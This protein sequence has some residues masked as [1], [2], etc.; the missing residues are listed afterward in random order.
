[1][2][3]S[4]RILNLILG[5]L[6]IIT[7]LA[8]GCTGSTT[9]AT[10]S[11][12]SNDKF[13]LWSDGTK[14]RG[15]NI[16]QRIIYP[17][18]YDDPEIWGNGP[19]GPVYTQADFNALESAGANFV[20]LSHPG[21]YDDQPPYALNTDIQNN[22]D[23]YIDMAEKA[24]LFV[25]ISFRTGPGRSEFSF[26]GVAEDDAFGQAHL[27]DDVWENTAAQDKWVEMWRYTA[28]R[29][30]HQPNVVGYELMV[31][32]NANGIWLDLW[33]PEDFY[34][35]YQ[36][37]TYDWNQLY[38]RIITA[39]REFDN[40][41]PIIVGA[42]GWSAVK[43]LPSLK[44]V[45]DN[46]IVYAIH[47]YEPQDQYV[48]QG[49][50]G[51]GPFPNTYPGVFDANYDG[52]NEDFNKAWINDL[53]ATVN[54]FKTQHSVPVIATEYGVVRWE[55]GAAQFLNDEMA[56]FEASGINYA[57]WLWNPSSPGYNGAH[58]EMN[59]RFGADPADLTEGHSD[60]LN[61]LKQY[62]AKNSVR[63]SSFK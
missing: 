29:Y 54:Q 60:L 26:F 55:P 3:K 43:W 24:D 40:D 4:G 46:R 28:T 20:V 34:P 51:T 31:E 61:V 44:T 50:D 32:P 9:T 62:W 53:L 17:N 27:N 56:S 38:P 41:T 37:S 23:R 63:L 35:T 25:V 59:Y 6:V 58:N 22:L 11:T 1:M 14:L 57:I 8:A 15:A 12:T 2:K 7:L 21:L 13:S 47:Q 39:I 36:N 42:M 48:L 10:T 52:R 5:L 16:Y 49:A 18:I 30:C 19:L 45:A 33:N